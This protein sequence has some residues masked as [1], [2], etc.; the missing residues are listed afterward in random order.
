[1]KLQVTKQINASIERVYDVFTDL[2]SAAE[3]VS[4]IEAVEVLTDQPFG[5]GTRWKETRI[6]MGKSATETMWITEVDPPNGYTAEA[7]SCGTHYTSTFTFEPG[8]GG[9]LVT[10][11]FEGRPVTLGAKVLSLLGVLMKGTIRKMLAKDLDDLAVVCE[12]G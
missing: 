3:R 12:Q 7:E 8:D 9:T 2:P 5:V 11:T 1:M 6:M 4:G 10:M